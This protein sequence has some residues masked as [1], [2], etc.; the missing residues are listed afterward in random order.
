MD[1]VAFAV[2]RYALDSRDT[3]GVGVTGATA[4]AAAAKAE[5]A[6]T[7]AART[8]AAHTVHSAAEAA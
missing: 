8:A 3:N 7:E 1:A 4:S 5:A 6:R 2:G